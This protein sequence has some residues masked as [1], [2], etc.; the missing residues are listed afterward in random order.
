MA[1]VGFIYTLHG[2]L[3]VLGGLL[4]GAAMLRAGQ[5]PRVAVLL[6]LCGLTLNLLFAVIPLPEIA[7]IAGS[8]L[9]NVGLIGMGPAFVGI[10][11]QV[12]A[13]DH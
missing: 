4:F 3:M 10:L 7:Q 1:T 11:R 5:L 6:F 9:R 12:S 8:A 13:G 2:A